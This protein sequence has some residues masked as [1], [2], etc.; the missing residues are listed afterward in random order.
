[1][2][3]EVKLYS[4]FFGKYVGSDEFDNRYYIAKKNSYNG[5]KK[6]WVIY[7]GICEAT[8]VPPAWH[9]WLH[10]TSDIVP[11]TKYSWQKPHLPNLTGTKNAYLPKGHLLRDGVRQK[12][13]SDYEAFDPDKIC[14][15]KENI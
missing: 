10:Y 15:L 7:N 9:L 3:F 2:K 11:Q 12:S 14:S 13:T 1:M 6:R 4:F 5:K 8:K